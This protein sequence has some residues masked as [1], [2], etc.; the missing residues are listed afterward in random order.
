MYIY[1]SEGSHPDNSRV[2]HI[3]GADD[4]ANFGHLCG[5]V[6]KEDYLACL[7]GQEFKY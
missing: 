4:N 7:Q 5:P 1:V 2:H 3:L 6:S